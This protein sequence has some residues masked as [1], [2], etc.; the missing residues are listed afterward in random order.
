MER[1]E[2][3]LLFVVIALVAVTGAGMW[4]L[5]PT[6][7]STPV[8]PGAELYPGVVRSATTYD[9]PEDDPAEEFG[10]TRTGPCQE[11]DVEIVGGPDEGTVFEIDTGLEDYPVFDAGDRVRVG[12][13][14]APGEDPNYY[15]ADFARIRPL[16]VLVLLFFAVAV[17]IGRW[18][19]V[20]SLVGLATS[21]AVIVAFIVPAILAGENPFLVA[22]VGALAVMLVTL[23]LAHG[24]TVKTTAAVVGTASALALTAIL[25]LVFVEIAELTGFSSEEA[26][27][28]RFAIQ[29]LD[30]R[31]LVLAGLVIG[32][33]GVLDDVTVSQASTVF[34]VHDANPDQGW[35]DV[36]R[37]AM[38]VGR[39]HIA[40]TVNT[41]VLAYVGASIPLIVLFT[42]SGS[43]VGEIANAEVVAEE[44]VKTLVG[45]IGLISA[46]PLTTALATSVAIRREVRT[47][48]LPPHLR[49][50]VDEDELTEEELAHRRWIAFLREGS[51]DIPP[52]PDEITEAVEPDGSGPALGGDDEEPPPAEE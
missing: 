49:E 25:G 36:F 8:F 23:Y 46:V 47:L 33:L 11:V 48:P 20:R 51:A 41:L 2:R 45:S 29:G 42:S 18:H 30:L 50:D 31:G 9:C 44:I 6:P 7:E 16:L 38:A 14:S 5:W 12:I 19:G 43:P 52:R 13:A 40:S 17:A 24:L 27:L 26:N 1:I 15:V 22:V 39:D 10:F 21:L 28:A 37:R 34:A 3:T 4:W 35:G 32:A